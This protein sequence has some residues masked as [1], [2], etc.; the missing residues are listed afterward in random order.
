MG[1]KILVVDD[2]QDYCDVMC[3]ILSGEGHHVETCN[4]GYQAL[5]KLEQQPFHIVLTDLMMPKMDGNQLLSEIKKKYTHIEVIMMTAYG[6][7]E[8]AVEAMRQGA[9]TYVTKGENPEQLL[10][11]IRRLAKVKNLMQEN[12]KLR[13]K[14]N[15]PDYLLESKNKDFQRTIDIAKKAAESNANVLVLGE[16]GVGKEV[17]ARFIHQ[18]SQRKGENFVDLNCHAIPESVLESELFG[19][20]KGSFTGASYKRIGRFEDADQGTLFLDEIGDIPLS[21]QAKL[22]KVLENKKLYPVGSNHAIDVDFRLVTATNKDLKK[23]I[24][25]ENFR[26][27]LFYR[28][29]TFVIEIPP[30]RDR[31]E[32]I[33]QFI[34]YFL[35][36]SQ[37]DMKKSVEKI[38]N[39]VMQ[40]L[41]QY[42]YP[43]NIREMKNIIERLVVLADEGILKKEHLSNYGGRAS[44]ALSGKA[45]QHSAY[46]C[47]SEESKTLREVRKEVECQYI[48][49][50]I[51]KEQGNL[52][53]VAEILGITRRQLSNKLV[54][55]DI[56]KQ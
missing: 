7:I 43:G 15:T 40:Y 34:Q 41:L 8:K 36:K 25:L 11:E 44:E 51:E 29:S 17:L 12:K 28:L 39:E 1:L 6:T 20:E 52:N 31:R 16:S 56:K 5:K 19:H 35:K 37:I 14:L 22:L 45:S 9:Y 27:D 42:N 50:I 53:R 3:M 46:A 48:K 32:D 23:E 33:P 21:T 24:R 49:K 54:E 10:A 13:E 4:D 2:E 47:E 30:L 55:F 38:E 26:E 18:H